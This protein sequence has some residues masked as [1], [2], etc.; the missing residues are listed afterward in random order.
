MFQKR[1]RDASLRQLVDK[2]LK[3]QSDITLPC[4]LLWFSKKHSTLF[5]KRR[6][7]LMANFTWVAV[8]EAEIRTQ[9]DE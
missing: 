6:L 1:T 5:R 4:W 7:G 9:T 2:R 8:L 3:M